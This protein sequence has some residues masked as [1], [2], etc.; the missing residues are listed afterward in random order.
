MMHKVSER[1]TMDAACWPERI[2]WALSEK[3]MLKKWVAE[4]CHKE[5]HGLIDEEEFAVDQLKKTIRVEE[6]NG[7]SDSELL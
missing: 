2:E 5:H 1:E 3:V 6:E 4:A 7:R